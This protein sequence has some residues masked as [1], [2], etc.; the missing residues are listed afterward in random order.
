M[1][2]LCVCVCVCVALHTSPPS[3]STLSPTQ[4]Q[5]HKAGFEASPTD[6]SSS[7]CFLFFCLTVKHRLPSVYIADYSGQDTSLPSVYPHM[8]AFFPSLL[9]SH[10][11]PSDCQS[12][13]FTQMYIY[14]VPCKCRGGSSSQLTPGKPRGKVTRCSLYHHLK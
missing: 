8:E 1:L 2:P 5:E 13:L 14:V 9:C 3:L 11:A 6:P 10:D 7:P 4:A 12:C